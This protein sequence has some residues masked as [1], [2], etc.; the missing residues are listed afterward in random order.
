M[1]NIT[2]FIKKNYIIALITLFIIIISL[3]AG[4]SSFKEAKRVYHDYDV[5]LQ[6]QAEIAETK[7]I[8]TVNRLKSD[9]SF[10]ASVPP[11]QGIIRASHNNDQDP[12]ENSTT[13][14][15]VKRLN[16]IFQGYIKS[17]PNITQVRYIEFANQGL[18]LVR[19]DQ[20]ANSIEVI[21]KDKLIPT[22]HKTFFKETIKLKQGKFFVSDITQTKV[23]AST[24]PSTIPTFIVSTPVYDNNDNLFGLLAITYNA[25]NLFKNLKKTRLNFYQLYLIKE[26]GE[27][28]INP[29]LILHSTDNLAKKTNWNEDFKVVSK[30]NILEKDLS[31]VKKYNQQ[32]FLVKDKSISLY[33]ET[34]NQLFLKLIFPKAIITSIIVKDFLNSIFTMLVVTITLCGL[35]YLYRFAV[36][37]RQRV[38]VEQARLA[39]IVE[40]SEDAIISCTLDGTVT[41]WN[42]SAATMFKIP[43]N[44]AIGQHI[45]DLIVPNTRQH[46]ETHILNQISQ[47]NSISQFNTQRLCKDGNLLDVSVSVSPVKNQKNEII[48]VAKIVRDISQQVAT[49]NKIRTLNA[50]LEKQVAERTAEIRHYLNLQSAILKQAPVAIIITNP[51]GVITLFNPAAEKMLGYHPDEIINKCT[52]LKFIQMSDI[53]QVAQS[54]SKQLNKAVGISFETLVLEAKYSLHHNEW[55]YINKYQSPFPVYQEIT[56]LLDTSS[57]TTG[58]LFIASDMTQQVAN[59]KKLESIRD[60]LVKASEVAQLG[61]WTWN[62]ETNELDWNPLMFKM[63]GISPPASGSKLHLKTWLK[64]L[65]PDDKENAYSNVLNTLKENEAFEFFFRIIRQDGSIRH[66]K[67]SATIERDDVYKV[68]TVLGINLD[69]TEQLEKELQLREAKANAE[70]ANIAKSEFVANMSHE[71]RTP[72][73]AILGMI[74]LLKL[75]QLSHK[76]LDYVKRTESA[77]NV[78]LGILNDILDFSKI[79][80]RKLSLDL[81]PCNLEHLLNNIG[82]I[83]SI[84][85]RDKN[86]EILF[87]IEP[88]IPMVILADELRLQQVLINLISNAIKFTHQGEVIISIKRSSSDYGQLLFSVIDSGI[89]IPLDKL[90]TIFEDFCQAETSTTRRFGGTGL[91]LAICKRLIHLMGGILSVESEIDKG[92]KFSFTIPYPL[93]DSHSFMSVKEFYKKS[94]TLQNIKILIAS[95]NSQAICFLKKA[96]DILNWKTGSANTI[97]QLMAK[98]QSRGDEYKCLLIDT[99]LF[100]TYKIDAISSLQESLLP[101]N[102]PIVMMMTSYQAQHFT[103]KLENIA[104]INKPV[105]PS[106][107]LST[108]SH[109]VKPDKPQLSPIKAEKNE[110]LRGLSILLVEDNPTNQLVA[111]KLLTSAGAN[112][113]VASDGIIAVNT[114]ENNKLPFDVVLMDIQ[115]PNMDGYTATNIIRTKLQQ[116]KTLPII[117]M[118]ANAM[119]TD[120]KKALNAGMNNHIGKPFKLKQV[121]TVILHEVQKCQNNKSTTH[122]S[123][124]YTT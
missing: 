48:G 83:A 5:L 96:A 28:L 111:K 102:I 57:N 121:I 9:L 104:I 66:I 43:S 69:I 90:E 11:I 8:N 26:S 19:I 120:K 47:G 23:N 75:T 45:N 103:Q 62:I 122:N 64:F 2:N 124:A 31:E 35:F 77:A 37:E 14:L 109:A 123:L 76:Q 86:V 29:E 73:N 87:D 107:L 81:Q 92:S 55:H 60:Q 94:H 68:K 78:L 95:N 27:Y 116:C 70:K 85:I 106:S 4:I 44:V 63:Y 50:S 72:M 34:S 82:T 114:L 24:E 42:N 38:K 119:E 39:A 18:E 49:E 12:Q 16:I 71:I 21:S 6:S 20:W 100:E 80:A 105:T 13:A 46:E 1:S 59:R 101:K 97:D 30:T 113:T 33:E 110:S 93:D 54:L 15:W 98:L 17:H 67:S 117:A 65:H 7:F 58:Y 3:L 61:I 51:K 91:G 52:P 25:N 56:P 84:N 108:V 32:H 88:D 36:H 79:E 53:A 118:T 40:S 10:F 22:R 112:V 89:G 115:M 99:S 74:E 41:N